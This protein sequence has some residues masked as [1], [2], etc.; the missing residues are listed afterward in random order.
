MA[1]IGLAF[2]PGEAAA[3]LVFHLEGRYGRG[4]KD[5][6]GC[7][8]PAVRSGRSWRVARRQSSKQSGALGIWRSR[9]HSKHF[10]VGEPDVIT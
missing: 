4:R 3:P 10:E 7:R 8:R 5:G 2:S 6:R 1:D 9:F